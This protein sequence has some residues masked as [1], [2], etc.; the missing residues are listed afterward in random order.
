MTH[1]EWLEQCPLRLWRMAQPTPWT[2]RRLARYLG[3]T[4]W[5]VLLWE[6]GQRQSTEDHWQEVQRLTGVTWAAWRAWHATPHD[7]P[8]AA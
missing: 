5:A 2:R 8:E 3:V 4:R 7:A 6:R 1:V